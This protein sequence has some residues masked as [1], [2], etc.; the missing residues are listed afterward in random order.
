MRTTGPWGRRATGTVV[1]VVVAALAGLAVVWAAAVPRPEPPIQ[2]AHPTRTLSEARGEDTQLA[3][4]TEINAAKYTGPRSQANV[5]GTALGWLA[6]AIV[7]GAV[8][9]LLVA[10]VR[11]WLASRQDRGVDE[12]AR[13]GPDLERVGAALALDAEGRLGALGRGTPAEGIIAAWA[14]LE[15]TLRGS[16]VPLPASR[17]STETTVAVLSRFRVDATTLRSLAE[18]Y[19]EASWSAHP[20][21][22]DDRDRAEGALRELDAAL[23]AARSVSPGAARG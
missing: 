23:S 8:L 22:E 21:T 4:R 14:R 9:A 16:G 5:F 20:L 1:L 12:D 3:P 11:A 18:L 19:R 10:A 15:E 2:V 17:T 13:A 7:A 6:V